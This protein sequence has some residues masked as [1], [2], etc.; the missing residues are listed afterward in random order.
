MKPATT[1][2]KILRA[3]HK[4]FDADGVDGVSMRR[5]A[6]AVGIT[7]M[8]I[9]RHFDSREA[10]LKQISDNSFDDAARDWAKQSQHKDVL[11]RLLA[12]QE[13]YL[14]YALAH[15]HLFDHAFSVQRADARQFPEAFRQRQSPTFNLVADAV[16]EGMNQ[17]VLREDDPWDVAMTLWAQA[18]GLIALY[19]AGRFN[20]NAKQFRQYYLA[21]IRRL[22]NGI[23]A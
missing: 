14:D 21:S 20:Y 18:H 23:T 12:T 11:R 17:G 5:V 7:P 6:D 19:R 15:P 22:L 3:A 10:L 1:A 2:D 13:L 16:A 8:A 4:L 9:Y